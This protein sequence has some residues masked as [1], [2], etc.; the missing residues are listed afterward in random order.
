LFLSSKAKQSLWGIRHGRDCFVALLLAMTP[1]NYLDGVLADS[2]LSE[3]A[4]M[5]DCHNCLNDLLERFFFQ[6]A[7][8]VR[9]L[10]PGLQV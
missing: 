2:P 8:S 10:P 9:R 7:R 1:Q 5:K 6:G 3:K 4:G